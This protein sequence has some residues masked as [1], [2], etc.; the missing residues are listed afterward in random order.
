[1]KTTVT[2]A[3]PILVACVL[4]T[5][6]LVSCNASGNADKNDAIVDK[7]SEIRYN[8]SEGWT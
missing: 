2:K 6:S 5:Y 4:A 8:F 1:M 3:I 7:E